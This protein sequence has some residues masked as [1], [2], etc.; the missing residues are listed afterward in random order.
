VNGIFTTSTAVSTSGAVECT[1]SVDVANTYMPVH[2]HEHGNWRN[3]CA[4]E[5]VFDEL[6][7]RLE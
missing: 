2:I 4:P 6:E 1:G 3:Y 7:S 5:Y